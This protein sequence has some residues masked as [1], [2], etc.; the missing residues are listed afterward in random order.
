VRRR[1]RVLAVRAALLVLLSACAAVDDPEG[2]SPD[3]GPPGATATVP[4]RGAATIRVALARDPMSLDP[5]RS[6]DDEGDLVVRALFDGL[7]DVAPD[8]HVV[9]AAAT[10]TVSDDALT[11]R[12]ALRP[13]R[14]HDGSEVTAQHHA[15][16]LLA[17]LDPARAPYYRED[18]LT[19]LRGAVLGPAAMT[20]GDG[21]AEVDAP[22]TAIRWGSPEDV[23]AAGGLEVT[24][25][26]ELVVRLARP[27]PM[28]LS[29]LTD[30]VLAPLPRLAVTDPDRFAL[31]PVGNG[32]FRM[33]GPRE[34]GAFI[35]LGPNMAHPTPP[36]F[37]EL[38]LQVYAGDAAREQRWADLVAG[39]L[40]IT[41]VPPAR[42]DEARER[43][44]SP[45]PGRRGP[46]LH[47][48]P[49][50]SVYAYG[51]T[52]DVAPFDRPELR[53]AISAAIDRDAIARDLASAGVEAATAILP[54]SLGGVMPDCA[55]CR[56]D[57]ALARELAALWRA[58]LPDGSDEPRISITYPRGAGHVTIAERIAADI[59]RTLGL[60]VQL[61]ARD[62][63]T[64]AQAV[65]GGEAPLFRYGLVARSGGEAAAVSL[66]DPALR[67][68]HPDNVT[69]WDGRAAELLDAWRPGAD[70]Q[71]LRTLEEA[72]LGSA[73]IVPVLW[74]RPDLVVH[75]DVRGFR[76]DPTGRW[77]PEQLRLGRT[78]R[79]DGSSQAGS[80]QR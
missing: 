10:W 65:T 56:H 80:V 67:P 4:E 66:L 72:V 31:E 59:E 40:Q 53:R 24:G 46:G 23:I 1:R 74:T 50:A 71:L 45:R 68:G 7:V 16:A 77:W 21:G 6:A 14:F 20:P 25:P 41:A 36:Q 18:L 5:R 37:D 75:P 73:A 22:T 43:F 34:P 58:T 35:R 49:G 54:A 32:P 26:L 76:L 39:R 3:P 69:G 57:P 51:F 13:D 70:P 28:L 27:D 12:F 9:P 61:Q 30:P 2:G 15:D 60:D 11:Y 62:P 17:V 52:V 42:R 48:L 44:G 29:R 64:F 63:V 79:T 8:G 55:H 38:L 78:P 19:S 47:D 33:L